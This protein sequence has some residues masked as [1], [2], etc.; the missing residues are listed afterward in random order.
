MGSIETPKGYYRRN[1]VLIPVGVDLGEKKENL[2]SGE[3]IAQPQQS[4]NAAKSD[5]NLGAKLNQI[6]ANIKKGIKSNALPVI[7]MTAIGVGAYF[8]S[9]VIKNKFVG[10]KPPTATEKESTDDAQMQFTRDNAGNY[11]IDE[12]EPRPNN[13]GIDEN[14]WLVY[15]K[16]IQKGTLVESQDGKYY[17]TTWA[18]FRADE[19]NAEPQIMTYD[20]GENVLFVETPEMQK[21][22]TEPGDEKVHSVSNISQFNL[23][24]EEE[25]W[26]VK[27]CNNLEALKNAKNGI[28]TDRFHNAVNWYISELEAQ[29]GQ[30]PTFLR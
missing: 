5:S 15:T 9:D 28:G 29:T 8:G 2:Q 13:M 12:N 21:T 16:G 27:N 6:G 25:N 17:R 1:G 22:E 4:D 7:L 30:E 11:I 20:E 24:P 3:Q 26:L 10:T 19:Q 23:S 14:G 18:K